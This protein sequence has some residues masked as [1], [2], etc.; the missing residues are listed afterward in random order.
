MLTFAI[1]DTHH[2]AAL[3]S[4]ITPT[5][6]LEWDRKSTHAIFINRHQIVGVP[7]DRPLL[8]VHSG[9]FKELLPSIRVDPTI[10][11]LER[12]FVAVV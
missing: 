6:L 12:A 7:A 2:I 9:G 8:V 11:Y 5:Q 10:G 3:A 1:A 4:P